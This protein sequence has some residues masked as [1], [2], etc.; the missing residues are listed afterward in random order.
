MPMKKS[1]RDHKISGTTIAAVS[2]PVD[3]QQQ[4]HAYGIVE[5]FQ[6][7]E[8]R[9]SQIVSPLPR[10]N[11]ETNASKNDSRPAAETQEDLVYAVLE[12][13]Q[14]NTTVSGKDLMKRQEQHESPIVRFTVDEDCDYYATIVGE[15][16]PI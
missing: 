3:S 8:V 4:S 14:N 6:L 12:M 1:R 10:K 13:G 2:D 15:L 7:T 16:R 11:L 9:P 5:A